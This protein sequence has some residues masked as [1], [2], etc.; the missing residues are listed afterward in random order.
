[1]LVRNDLHPEVQDLKGWAKPPRTPAQISVFVEDLAE[2]LSFQSIMR[3]ARDCAPAPKSGMDEKQGC[4]AARKLD[5]NALL[6]V[7]LAEA[8]RPEMLQMM[9]E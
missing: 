2:Y 7:L 4:S 3:N 1:M 6:P 8:C 5:S 9:A